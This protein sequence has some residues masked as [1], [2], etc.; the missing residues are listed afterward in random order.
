[1][2]KKEKKRSIGADFASTGFR[3]DLLMYVAY[4]IYILL[5]PASKAP[6]FSM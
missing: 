2:K 4:L 6:F 3:R 5:I 1:V